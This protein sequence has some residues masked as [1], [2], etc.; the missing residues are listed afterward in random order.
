MKECVRLN[1]SHPGADPRPTTHLPPPAPP[2]RSEFPEQRRL[3]NMVTSSRR[4]SCQSPGTLAYGVLQTWTNKAEAAK[5]LTRGP[6]AAICSTPRFRS[7][8]DPATPGSVVRTKRRL[9]VRRRALPR[10]V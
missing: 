3:R 4:T 10:C 7:G 9:R 2:W 1:L 6:G 8:E 5:D